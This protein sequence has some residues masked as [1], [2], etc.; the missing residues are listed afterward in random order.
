MQECIHWG[1]ED[2]YNIYVCIYIYIHIY[3]T[4]TIIYIHIYIYIFIY[5]TYTYI[6][7]YIYIYILT[8][9]IYIYIYTYMMHSCIS[10]QCWKLSQRRTSPPKFWPSGGC[11]AQG[12]VG[13][14][15][16]GRPR[17]SRKRPR[18]HG[19]LQPTV[20][21]GGSNCWAC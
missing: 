10:D 6:Y 5:Y 2:A 15:Q 9:H 11:G 16:Q 21:L 18:S 1:N 7:I 19:G 12:P 14:G 13:F 8:I 20:E 3:N 17:A 4:Y